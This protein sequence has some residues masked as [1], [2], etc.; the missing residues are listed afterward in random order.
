[1]QVLTFKRD[2]SSDLQSSIIEGASGPVTS[3]RD[4][5]FFSLAPG[6]VCLVTFNKK[7]KNYL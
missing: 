3:S 4:F 7:Y 2:S 5:G 1:M 6:S